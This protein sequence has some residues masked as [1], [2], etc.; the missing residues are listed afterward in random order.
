MKL[1]RILSALTSITVALTANFFTASAALEDHG[2]PYDCK[3]AN[4]DD[5]ETRP[6]MTVSKKVYRSVDEI[7][8]GTVTVELSIDGD[9]C[10]INNKFCTT[11]LRIYWDTRLIPIQNQDADFVSI[12]D[13]I[14]PLR[15]PPAFDIWDNNTFAL[16]ATM[17]SNNYGKSGVMWKMKFKLPDNATDGDIYPIDVCYGKYALFTNSAD[18]K[19]GKLMQAYFFTRGI[20]SKENPSDDPYLIKAG[21]AFA[22]GYIAIDSKNPQAETNT[23]KTAATTTTSTTSTTSATTTS[24]VTATQPVTTHPLG[25]INGDD[26]V[27]GRDAT[28]I[29]TYYAKTSTGYKGTLEDFIKSQ[30]K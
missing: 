27:D 13:A 30:S 7:E 29:L 28:A 11:C 8:D 14:N 10:D 26:I 25:D 17:G 9:G 5:A 21:A 23:T 12:G 1:R 18:D 19:Q 16:L 20:H 4:G 3:P 22:D 24:V 6:V 2:V 15:L